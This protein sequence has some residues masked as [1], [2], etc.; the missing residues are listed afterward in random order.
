MRRDRVNHTRCGTTLE[1]P[2]G[3][4]VKKGTNVACSSV[5]SN[6]LI[7]RLQETEQRSRESQPSQHHENPFLG[8][9][10][11]GLAVVVRNKSW[12]FEQ[13]RRT[14]GD[15]ARLSI[16][17]EDVDPEVPPRDEPSLRK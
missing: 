5:T 15:N 11:E 16:Q 13:W 4:I 7:D 2:A 17:F 6:A 10:R 9:R 1:D 12:E 14:G 3:N 8:D